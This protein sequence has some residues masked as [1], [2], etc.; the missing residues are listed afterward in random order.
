ME[1]IASMDE[2]RR[3]RAERL[4]KAQENA[5][6]HKEVIVYANERSVRCMICGAPL[7]PFDVLVDMV[8]RYGPGG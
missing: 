2:A 4:R 6:G 5:C 1:K 7:D 8:Q 3:R